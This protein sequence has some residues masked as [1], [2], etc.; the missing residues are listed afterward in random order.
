MQK[1]IIKKKK[2]SVISEGNGLAGWLAGLLWLDI[3]VFFFT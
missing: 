2:K 3:W 1:K